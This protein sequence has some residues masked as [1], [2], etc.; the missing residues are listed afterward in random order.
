MPLFLFLSPT[1]GVDASLGAHAARIATTGRVKQQGPGIL[2]PCRPLFR[3]PEGVQ[4]WMKVCLFRG[5]WRDCSVQITYRPGY[6][7]HDCS[8]G[9]KYNLLLQ[10]SG[11]SFLLF[12]LGPSSKFAG[13]QP[14]APD[15][16]SLCA[17][18]FIGGLRGRRLPTTP[19]ARRHPD[20]DSDYLI[21]SLLQTFS[22]TLVTPTTAITPSGSVAANS[23]STFAPFARQQLHVSGLPSVSW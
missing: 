14:S 5:K 11:S 21:R 17:I 19:C 18:I 15:S 23:S 1:K 4:Y 16:A 8:T 12:F 13:W 3:C 2:N 6:V 7:G 9:V 20:C 10:G 22:R